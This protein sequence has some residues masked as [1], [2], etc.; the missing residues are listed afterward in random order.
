MLILMFGVF[1]YMQLIDKIA[2]FKIGPLDCV[3]ERLSGR[4]LNVLLYIFLHD[5]EVGFIYFWY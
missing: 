2:F 5:G 4:H 3:P 1:R